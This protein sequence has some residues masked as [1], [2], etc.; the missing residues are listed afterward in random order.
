MKAAVIDA[1]HEPVKVRD[2]PKTIPRPGEAVVNIKAA[3]LNHRDVFIQ[4]GLYAKIRLPFVPGSDGAGI[5]TEVGEGVD[6]Q[7]I[8]QEVVINCSLGWGDNPAFQS[9]NYHIL[10]MPDDG[11]LAEIVKVP[12]NSL[13]RKPKHL[14]FEEAGALPLAGLTAWR[15]LVTKGKIKDNENV[16][17]TGIGG[18]V[19]Q[20]ALMFAGAF[21]AN[22]YVTSSDKEKI[23]KAKLRGAKGGVLYTEPVWE[24]K[25]EE[26]AGR[27]HLIVDGA[28][29]PDFANLVEIAE[30]AGRIVIYGGTAGKLIGVSPQRIFWKQLSIFGSTMGSDDEFAAM[31]DFVDQQ[32]IRPVV[33]KVYSLEEV[34]EAFK[35]MDEGRQFGKIIVKA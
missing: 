8:G 34:N 16:L 21:G 15:A 19:A 14:T 24:K 35:R 26:E 5:V 7:W 20:A 18:G 1:L 13:Q 3:A 11:T 28:A 4:Q 22:V 30:Y 31:L 12:V 17:I 25:L 32:K 29:G 33:D 2:I 10:G 9:K 6:S 27:F 23:D